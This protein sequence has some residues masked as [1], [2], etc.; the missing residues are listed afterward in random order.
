MND[1]NLSIN[2]NKTNLIQFYPHQR[3]PPPLKLELN[4]KEIVQVGN[5]KLLGINLDSHMNWKTHISI[6]KTKISQF[7]YGL[8]TLRK[9]TDFAT[10][11]SAYYAYAHSWLR[12]GIILWGNSTDAHDLFIMQKKCIRVLVGIRNRDSC[13][14]HFTKHG[15]LTLPCMY[16]LELCIFVRKNF[17]LF[18]KQQN[19]RFKHK[20]ILPVPNLEIFRNS[21]HYAAVKYYNQLPNY[22][23]AEEKYTTYAKKLKSY[24]LNKTYY[25]VEDFFSDT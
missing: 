21:P 13:R 2:I 17:H 11:L 15:V 19:K 23:K 8:F 3:T 24:L 6:T 1:H 7:L 16:I 18:E 5:F 12:Y 22:L 9:T 14:P 20:L 4:N 25:T 10:A